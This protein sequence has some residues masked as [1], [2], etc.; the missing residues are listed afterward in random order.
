MNPLYA[1][2]P[3]TIF[4]RMSALAVEHDA[5]NLG[6]GFPDFGW[7]DDVVAKAAEALAGSNQYAP[8]PGLAEL[9]AAVA[10]HYRRVQGV[11]LDP[12][13]VTVT[14]GATEALAAALF[15]LI[16]PGDEVLLF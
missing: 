10:A 12:D 3:T 9:R 14:S 11:D 2:L 6:Q 15:A 5:V 13:A 4:S 8:M 7:P 1:N 16:T